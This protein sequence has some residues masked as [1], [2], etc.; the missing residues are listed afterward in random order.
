MVRK[1]AFGINFAIIGIEQ[2]EEID[3]RIPLRQMSYEAGEYE[4]QA[5]TIRKK[6]R[7][8]SKYSTVMFDMYS[9]SFVI[10]ENQRG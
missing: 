6:V 2:Q 3:Y 8:N 1:V 5:A 9:R 4:N 10:H 7:N